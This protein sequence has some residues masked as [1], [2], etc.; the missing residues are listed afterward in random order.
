MNDTDHKNPEAEAGK[1][2]V[3][4][5][6]A[7]LDSGEIVE[8]IYRR[9]E[10]RTS[11]V[12]FRGGAWRE[13]SFLDLPGG[14]RCIP[15][16][17]ENN[18]LRHKVVLLPSRPEEYGSEAALLAEVRSFIHRYVDLTPTFEEIASY[19]VL[20]TWIYDAFNE[21][22]YLR[23]RGDFGSGKSR[24]LLTVGS[25]C[26]KPIFASG[27]STVSPIFRIIDA[28]GGTLVIDEGDFRASD[29]K[30]EITKILNNGNARGF[31]VLRSEQMGQ[32]KEFDP[33]AYSVFGPK[34]IAT[35]GFFEDRA[36]ESRCITEDLGERPLRDDI[37]L[38]LPD[39]FEEEALAL[40]NKLLLFRFHNLQKPRD[41]SIAVDRS[42][43][44]RLAQIFA[45]LMSTIE[46]TAAR[47]DLLTLAR[48]YQRELVAD[49]GMDLEAQLLEVI[50][51]LAAAGG[52]L[53][54]REIAVRFA[55]RHADDYDRPMTPKRVGSIIRRKLGLVPQKS[56]GVFVVPP[57]EQT[58]LQRL[59][60]KYG[61]ESDAADDKSH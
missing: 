48:R 6:S 60:E 22:P 34:L 38:N 1:R 21:L 5:V 24:F 13:A 31:P 45:P 37:P 11:F 20:F 32:R 55:E 12:L 9:K 52:E 40:R 46:D 54:V 36:L 29:E 2:T 14:E 59:Y 23:V 58:K 30:A 19:Y 10:A 3:A 44:P 16:R 47:A 15:Y 17:S 4:T 43:E 61:I 18:L 57:A 41:L 35:R 8:M 25:L 39:A 7:V 33:R 27:A 50:R 42:I 49:R 53:S 51:D 56:H 26:Y 28:F